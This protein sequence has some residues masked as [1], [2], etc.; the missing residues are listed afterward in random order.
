MLTP[1]QTVR[2]KRNAQI[3][4]FVKVDHTLGEA[5][6]EF[7]VSSSTVFNLCRENGVTAPRERVTRTISPLRIIALCQQGMSGSAI[8]KDVGCSCQRVSQVLAEARKAGVS[9]LRGQ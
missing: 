9:G 5:A 6:R 4:K 7:K 1:K 2:R 8:A 3:V